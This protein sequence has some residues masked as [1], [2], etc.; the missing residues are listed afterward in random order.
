MT[1]K[2]RDNAKSIAYGLLYGMGPRALEN[3]LRQLLGC[4]ADA[5][6]RHRDAFMSA[7]PGVVGTH[8][9]YSIWQRVC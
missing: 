2:E 3:S 6:V 4:S 1:L 8:S 5:A 9:F 7:W